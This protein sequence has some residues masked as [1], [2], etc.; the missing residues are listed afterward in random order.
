MIRQLNQGRG[1][2]LLLGLVTR[3]EGKYFARKFNGL[4]ELSDEEAKKKKFAGNITLYYFK[5]MGQKTASD[6]L[7]ESSKPV[8][9]MQGG[10]DFQVLADDDFKA[11]KEQLADRS[12]ITYKLYP[13]LN[14]CFVP[15]IYDDILKA[16]KEYSVERHI[17][18]DVI[19][20]IAEFIYAQK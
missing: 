13:E 3:L 4:Y 17:G 16:S 11:F 9:I 6:Y 7:L 5:E 8:L 10:R 14:H 19:A 18:E 2:N 15:A 20:D 12:N 1:T